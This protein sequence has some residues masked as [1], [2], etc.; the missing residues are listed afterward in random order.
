MCCIQS[1]PLWRSGLMWGCLWLSLFRPSQA[2]PKK[3]NRKNS[4][5][6]LM[7]MPWRENQLTTCT[8]KTQ[9]PSTSLNPVASRLKDLPRSCD[10][11]VERTTCRPNGVWTPWNS[12]SEAWAFEL[13]HLP[14]LAFFSISTEQPKEKK[15]AFCCGQNTWSDGEVVVEVPDSKASNLGDTSNNL[16]CRIGCTQNANKLLYPI[17]GVAKADT[18]RLN[19]QYRKGP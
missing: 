14:H 4:N 16:R 19:L 12:F 11:Q 17:H 3:G 6:G 13:H 2:V 18:A 1:M 15:T 5:R 8:Q 10:L 9:V 7:A